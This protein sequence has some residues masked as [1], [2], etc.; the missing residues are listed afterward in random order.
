VRRLVFAAR[1]LVASRRSLG[2]RTFDPPSDSVDRLRVNANRVEGAV[3]APASD[4]GDAVAGY[5]EADRS[6]YDVGDGVHEHFGATT[7]VFA[8]ADA[9]GVS[10]LVNQYADLS[11]RWQ[12][13]VDHDLTTMA[14]APTIDGSIQ[15]NAPNV[16]A[17][18]GRELLERLKQVGMRFAG[19]RLRWGADRHGV[20]IRDRIRLLHVEDRHR[21]KREAHVRVPGHTGVRSFEGHRREDADGLLASAYAAVQVEKGAKA[22]NERGVGSL[23]RY[24]QLV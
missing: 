11:V 10:E 20:A 21:A 12:A 24:E 4:V 5:V 23:Q 3:L 15:R 7:T 22:G 2:Q 17:E 18:L 9:E 13:V 14:V 1:D 6:A 19:D 8:V 16:V